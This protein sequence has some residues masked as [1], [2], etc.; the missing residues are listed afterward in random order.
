MRSTGK[1]ALSVARSISWSMFQLKSQDMTL[2]QVSELT[3]VHGST[4]YSEFCNERIAY[5]RL[6][7]EPWWS[8]R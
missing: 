4:S 8:V 6:R 7:R 2:A 5:S 1:S 3:G